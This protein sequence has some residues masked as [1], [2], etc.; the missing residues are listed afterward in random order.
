MDVD[1]PL[2]HTVPLASCTEE[3]R[4]ENLSQ[5]AFPQFIASN[6]VALV[7][8]H[9]TWCGPCRAMGPVIEALHG[10]FFGIAGIAKVD[11]DESP[12][13]AEAFGVRSIPTLIFFKDGQQ[14]EQLLGARTQDELAQKLR[15]LF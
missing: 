2:R 4:M 11:V 13:L 15:T 3:I 6:K 12:E 10:E 8:F 14:V 7:D 9:A 1:P 5:G